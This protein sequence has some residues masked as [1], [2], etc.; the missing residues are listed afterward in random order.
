[1]SLVVAITTNN[2]LKTIKINQEMFLTHWMKEILGCRVPHG[3]V[4]IKLYN[5]INSMIG[6]YLSLIVKQ[7][8]KIYTYTYSIRILYNKHTLVVVV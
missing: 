6:L 5:S 7:A 4:F 1:M 3:S 8:Q 2:V